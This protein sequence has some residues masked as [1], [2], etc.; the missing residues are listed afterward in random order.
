MLQEVVQYVIGGFIGWVLHGSIAFYMTRRNVRTYLTIAI[1]THLQCTKKNIHTLSDYV[2]KR[3]AIGKNVDIAPRHQA[4]KLESMTCVKAQAIQ[5][6][7]KTEITKLA[8][9]FFVFEEL[10]TLSDGLCIHLKDH[11]NSGKEISAESYSHFLRHVERMKH[12]EYQLPNEKESLND[13]PLAYDI[14]T[15]I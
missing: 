13:L 5:V 7:T 14:K 15:D 1:F 11:E 8:R 4:D 2:E 9:A 6:L 3:T 10:E 12:L